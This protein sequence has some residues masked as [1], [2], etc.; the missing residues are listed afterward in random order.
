LRG[1]FDNPW[2]GLTRL[3]GLFNAT[4]TVSPDGLC[5]WPIRGLYLWAK[6]DLD[7]IDRVKLPVM[8]DIGPLS[9]LYCYTPLALR[10]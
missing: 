6:V 2:P 5:T 10:P 8:G 1:R 4:S 7:M 9:D 3:S